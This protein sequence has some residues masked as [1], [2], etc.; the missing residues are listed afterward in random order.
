V[1]DTGIIKNENF[2]FNVYDTQSPVE[3]LIVHIGNITGT[4]SV[5]EEVTAEVDKD[6]R[7]AIKRAHTSTH[8]LQSVLRKEFGENLMQQGSEVK[9]DEFRFDFNFQNI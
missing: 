1:G 9:P 2:E 3:G 7:Q 5:G 6:R 4:V 8:I